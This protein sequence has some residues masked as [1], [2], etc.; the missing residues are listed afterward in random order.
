VKRYLVEEG[1]AAV[2]ALWSKATRA[3]ASE[4]P[5]NVRLRR[6]EAGLDRPSVVN[7]TQVRT[8]DKSRLTERIGRLSAARVRE[9]LAGLALV[10]GTSDDEF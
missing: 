6:R 2:E 5:G 7:V 9:V 8:L 1:S 4:M 10:F 3:V